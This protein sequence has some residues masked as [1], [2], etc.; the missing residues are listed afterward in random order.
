V[1]A[2]DGLDLTVTIVSYN[3]RDLLRACLA[4]LAADRSACSV[5][6]H[7]VDNHSSDGSPELV[8]A[9]FPHARVIANREN[10]G[11]ARA[12]NQSW[13]LA[14]GRY[15][16][17]LNSD[18]EVRPGVL[19]ALVQFMDAHPRAGLASARLVN[20][21]GSPQHCAQAVPGLARLLLEASR[22]HKL[23]PQ[24]VRGR[25]LLGPYWNYAQ[26]VRVGWTWGTALIARRAAIE[27]CGPLSEQFF[28]YGEDLEWCLRVRR[29]GWDVWFCPSAEVLHHGGQSPAGEAMPA[30]RL[31]ARLD[32]IYRAVE[33]HRGQR[34]V[35]W[36]R[37]V[38][39]FTLGMER[40][41]G[42]LRG[43]ATGS[44]AAQMSYY[45]TPPDPPRSP[46]SNTP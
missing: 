26:P 34:Y 20:L 10:V 7:V 12:N 36:L 43:R 25:I 23:L 1:I 35:R 6:V 4:S 5:E 2:A 41:A 28:M 30:D 15:W 16:L 24:S 37:R 21:D 33:V 18:A 39:L 13:H 9:A 42:Q 31:K 27:E 17:L 40:L 11:F 32:G 45:R 44:L 3:T 8:R 46:E 38:S 14:R 22:L 29:R 19:D